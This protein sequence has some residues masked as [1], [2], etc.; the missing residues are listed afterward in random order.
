MMPKFHV[1]GAEVQVLSLLKNLDPDR[2]SISLCLLNRGDREMETDASKYVDSIYYLGFRWRYLPWSFLKL[3]KY[4]QDGRFRVIHAHLEYAGL[5]GRL[6]G[7]FAGVPVR[8]TTEHGKNLWKSQF[9]LAIERMMNRITDAKICVS[10]DIAEIRRKNEGTPDEKLIYIPNAVDAG[11]FKES[12]SSKG[13]IMEEFGWQSDDPLILSVGRIVEAKNYPLLVDAIVELGKKIPEARCLIAG[14]GDQKEEIEK[15][16]G[17]LGVSERIKMAGTRRDIPELLAAAEIFTLSS[18][19]EGLPVSI[20]EAM[21]SGTPVVSTDVGGVGDAV[22]DGING[23]LVPSGDPAAMAK[24]FERMLSDRE[25]SKNLA[26]NGLRTVEEKFS[27]KSAASR[28]GD[29]YIELFQAKTGSYW[30]K[31]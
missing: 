20:L 17:S 22:T 3:V 7:W 31:S 5:I 13:R 1:G 29:I 16:I 23:L 4:L 2:F 15:K 28:L 6:A 25:F 14:D 19:R 27:I 21:A 12:S 18:V 30:Q 26:D 10:R 11:L 8:M 9:L 24:A